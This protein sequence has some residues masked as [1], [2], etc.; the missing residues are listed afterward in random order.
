MWL[1]DTQ[2]HTCTHIYARIQWGV[3]IHF[4]DLYGLLFFLRVEP[5]VAEIWWKLLLWKP[6]AEGNWTPMLRTC[7]KLLWRNSKLDVAE[8]V[9]GLVDWL[10]F[11]NPHIVVAVTSSLWV[12]PLVD[13]FTSGATFLPQDT[14]QVCQWVWECMWIVWLY[15]CNNGNF[16]GQVIHRFCYEGEE[17]CNLDNHTVSKV[18]GYTTYRIYPNR[19]PGIYFL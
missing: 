13:I 10:K 15:Y 6:F 14:G 16:I 12:C 4:A 1:C 19:S 2:M 17:L 18:R 3:L 5:Y 11:F 9:R 8:E 7:S